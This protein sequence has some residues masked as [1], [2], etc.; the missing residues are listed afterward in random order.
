MWGPVTGEERRIIR[1]WFG[2]VPL[3]KWA[4]ST[5]FDLKVK[6]FD[7]CDAHLGVEGP[8]MS[9]HKIRAA[10]VSGREERLVAAVKASEGKRL[11]Y[12]D[13]IGRKIPID[14]SDQDQDAALQGQPKARPRA[15][16]AQDRHGLERRYQ[17]VPAKE[18]ACRWLAE[19]AVRVQ[20]VKDARGKK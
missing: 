15:C 17:N 8:R 2:S 12:A 5:G 10:T 3:G 13:S 9:R 14:E 18:K 16:A 11:V 4:F 6:P 7:S 20:I 1:A 19:I